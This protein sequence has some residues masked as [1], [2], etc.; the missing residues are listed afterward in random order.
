MSAH[1]N[2]RRTLM[3]LAA[4]AAF[5]IG[6]C[7]GEAQMPNPAR[8]TDRALVLRSEVIFLGTTR[9]IEQL[10]SGETRAVVDVTEV[11]KGEVSADVVEVV[12]PVGIVVRDIEQYRELAGTD[13]NPSG[14]WF[15][16]GVE[17]YLLVD[18]TRQGY[19]LSG[20]EFPGYVRTLVEQLPDTP[21]SP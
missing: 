20:D 19:P 12:A 6:G 4:S 13:E 7:S 15:A 3:T 18:E 16:T 11:L 21:P 14:L 5:M 17:P 1:Q 8:Y 10:E 9:S 2:P